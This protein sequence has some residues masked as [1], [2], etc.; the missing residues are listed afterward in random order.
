MVWIGCGIQLRGIGIKTQLTVGARAMARASARKKIVDRYD[1]TY[2][3]VDE[4]ED[5][6]VSICQTQLV[7]TPF[8]SRLTHD[9]IYV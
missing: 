3:A 6:R 8:R 1:L 9:Q 7:N 2:H 4:R 5:L